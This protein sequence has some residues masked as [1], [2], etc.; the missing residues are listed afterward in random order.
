MLRDIPSV[1]ELISHFN[2]FYHFS[3]LKADIEKSEIVGIGSLKGVTETF[4][5]LKSVDLS[6]NTIKILEI[7]LSYNKKVQMPDNFLTTIKK[8]SK[9]FVSGI[10]VPFP[11]RGEICYKIGYLDLITNVPKVIVKELQKIQ[12][13]LW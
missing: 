12:K 6:N 13:K 8:Y 5:G 7:H 3:G 4:F 10:Q 9:F 2:Q 11:L 1:K